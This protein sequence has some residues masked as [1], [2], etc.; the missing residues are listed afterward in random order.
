MLSTTSP[1]LAVHWLAGFDSTKQLPLLSSGHSS[2][3]FDGRS[4][5]AGG[6]GART[7]RRTA[8]ENEITFFEL[9]RIYSVEWRNINLSFLALLLSLPILAVV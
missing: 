2:W 4:G 5:D 7:E 1:R 9:V 8:R 3:K 6:N